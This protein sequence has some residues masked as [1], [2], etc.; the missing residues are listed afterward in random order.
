MDTSPAQASVADAAPQASVHRVSFNGRGGEYFRI[1]IVNVALSVITL[2]IYSAWAKVRRLNYFYR[3]TSLAG[4]SFEYHGQPL[5]ILKGRILAVVLLVVWNVAPEIHL[6][7]FLVVFIAGLCILPWLINSAL[8]FR[9]HNSA[10]RGLRFR[11]LGRV[12]EAAKVFLLYPFFVLITLGIAY[13]YFKW[14]TKQF[15]F[16]HAAYGS[17]QAKFN[18]PLGPFFRLYVFVAF[19]GALIPLAIAL[20]LIVYFRGMFGDGSL[21]NP[22]D[23]DDWAKLLI[24]A[25]AVF[26]GFITYLGIWAFIRARLHV[27]C[28]DGLGI[29]DHR[30]QCQLNPWKFAAISLAN[31][32]LIFLTFGLYKPFSDIQLTGLLAQSIELHCAGDLSNALASAA[33][34][35]RAAGEEAA[36]IFDMDIGL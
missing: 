30:V 6:V 11:F 35:T 10:Y 33:V 14:R 9:L 28:W 4:S 15:F 13:P 36:E 22:G 17:L 8:R 5:A 7:F 32:A 25:P 20:S 21:S 26:V 12:K 24:I 29:G 3:N 27:V 19:L 2:G 1:W 31:L 34:E 23:L 16:S 18:A